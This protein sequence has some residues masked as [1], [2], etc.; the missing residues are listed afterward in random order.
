[1]K[2]GTT[3]YAM[4][5]D[6]QGRVLPALLE[7]GM[8]AGRVL[9]RLLN[10]PSYSAI[11]AG[12][13]QHLFT[14]DR[15]GE[16]SVYP[17]VSLRPLATGRAQPAAVRVAANVELPPV[18]MSLGMGDDDL[19]MA[20]GYPVARKTMEAL[21]KKT[22]S[23]LEVRA[24][25]LFAMFSA[26]RGNGE[27]EMLFYRSWPAIEDGSIASMTD[28]QMIAMWR[29]KARTP[30]VAGGI[31]LVALIPRYVR[32]CWTWA[33]A[34]HAA[35]KQGLKDRELRRHLSVNVGLPL[36]LG[37]V[38]L[39]FALELLGH[40]IACLDKHMLGILVGGDT[41]EAAKA[42][43]EKIMGELSEKDNSKAAQDR[44]LQPDW[45]F[46]KTAS[47]DG[48]EK[49]EDALVSG[50][51]F[52]S[53][54][55][56]MSYARCQWMTW[57][58]LRGEATLH[59]ALFASIRAVKTGKPF[60]LPPHYLN[61]IKRGAM[62]KWMRVRGSWVRAKK[63]GRAMHWREKGQQTE[64]MKAELKKSRKEYRFMP[65]LIANP[66]QVF[67]LY[68]D[69]KYQMAGSQADIMAWIHA[70]HSFSLAHALKYEGY[71]VK[72]AGTKKNPG[73]QWHMEQVDDTIAL[74]S[75]ASD[76]STKSYYRGK[77][78]S[79]FD[80]LNAQ[81]NPASRAALRRAGP[82][83]RAKRNP[84]LAGAPE[85]ESITVADGSQPQKALMAAGW[86]VSGVTGGKA[87][88]VRA[89][90]GGPRATQPRLFEATITDS[91][92]Q[93]VSRAEAAHAHRC[94]HAAGW[95]QGKVIA[96]C[97]V[98]QRPGEQKDD[99][100]QR[101]LAELG[102]PANLHVK[103]R[104]KKFSG[105]PGHAWHNRMA[106]TAS[107]LK[108]EAIA[109]GKQHTADVLLGAELAHKGSAKESLA[110]SEVVNRMTANPANRSGYKFCLHKTGADLVA[111]T[112]PWKGKVF[113]YITQL[114]RWAEK[115]GLR[116]KRDKSLFGGYY[117][118]ADGNAYMPDIRPK[119]SVLGNPS[120]PW[121]VSYDGLFGPV[122][123][124]FRSHK[125][126]VQWSRQVGVDRKSD[127]KITKSSSA[128]PVCNP[129][130]GRYKIVHFTMRDMAVAADKGQGVKGLVNW[131]S[132]E[133]KAK[134]L[135]W[136]VIALSRGHQ[137]GISPFVRAGV[138]DKK[139]DKPVLRLVR[140]IRDRKETWKE[141]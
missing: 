5:R 130:K 98:T 72:P 81:Q 1:M 18:Q 99:T 54:D 80:S 50:N 91:F 43:G 53:R 8:S 122:L 100:R 94:G 129:G 107:R 105:N 82:G 76:V 60:V 120:R 55:D 11:A 6:A 112:A 103:L 90:P 125:R 44:Q 52:F 32:S 67:K 96:Q 97:L 17:F 83:R 111:E 2:L 3:V 78:A 85:V 86:K 128:A 33:E 140:D 57:E 123:R 115:Q 101:L 7:P 65:R 15:G 14:L 23:L 42:R 118:D 79:H 124:K 47:I 104:P 64:A 21:R 92:R 121:S 13:V 135:C 27:C 30:G 95:V 131:A 75:G 136:E 93:Q 58:V 114:T 37:L 73:R 119:G 24:V 88:M 141:W 31:G 12:R 39:S 36:G 28:A 102:L 49:Y 9:V 48:Y 10:E 22:P 19:N 117:V 38:K 70:H 113:D 35:L 84:L 89:N 29:S 40:N 71:S 4:V 138:Y 41:V 126:A 74:A 87:V 106:R 46:I 51:E 69:G 34:L 66:G 109:S 139:T 77:L 25:V 45:K 134:E 132:S 16:G 59:D 127:L 133:K 26:N 68:R 110:V 20:T 116:F 108:R 62:M 137:G 63:V 61:R 56:P